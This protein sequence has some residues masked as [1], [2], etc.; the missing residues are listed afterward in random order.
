MKINIKTFGTLYAREIDYLL[1]AF[2]IFMIYGFK[3]FSLVDF[4]Q[5]YGN[6]FALLAPERQWVQEGPVNFFIGYFLSFFINYKVAYVS[7]YFLNLFAVVYAINIL[8]RNVEL[9]VF[10]SFLSVSFLTPIVVIP[11]MWA[12]KT[13]GFLIASII[14]IAALS[15]SKSKLI[16]I[17][18]V[19]GIFSHPSSFIIQL[20]GLLILGI[21][22]FSLMMKI[23]CISVIFYSFYLF[24]IGGL[25]GRLSFAS[26]N[27]MKILQARLEDPIFTIFTLF[28]FLWLF[29]IPNY[30]QFKINSFLY[31]FIIIGV[32]ALTLDTTRVF[33]LL[34]LPIL[35]HISFSKRLNE[36]YFEFIQ[37]LSKIL[38]YFFF[39]LLHFQ[40]WGSD[41]VDT[42]WPS[43]I[44]RFFNLF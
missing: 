7:I 9:S 28:G 24:T 3:L 18:A 14:S 34:S 1:C 2:L 22:R 40:M 43:L 41:S 32:V 35:I 38:P 30:K 12:G 31:L 29:L 44:A 5:L 19:I 37:K 13:D 33:S 16:Y 42:F 27:Y 25:E 36:L 20:F 26:E 23:F 15:N 39:S 4:N 10:K 11:L 6:P 8:K 17:W 21:T